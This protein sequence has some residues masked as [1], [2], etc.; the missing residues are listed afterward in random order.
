MNEN[1]REE[2]S[3]PE[4]WGEWSLSITL[5]SLFSYLTENIKNQEQKTEKLAI[6]SSYFRLWMPRVG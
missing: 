6:A 3:S 5:C 2:P 1:Q 4:K